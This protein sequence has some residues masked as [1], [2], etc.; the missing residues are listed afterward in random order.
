MRILNAIELKPRRTVRIALW[1][2]EEQ[3]LLGSKGYVTQ[4]FGSF[5]LSTAP[6]QMELPEFM[7]KAG[8]PLT[9]STDQ[10]HLRLFQ[11]GQEQAGFAVSTPRATLRW[12]PSLRNGWLR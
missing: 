9:L 6:D 3:G 12:I 8:G 1:S 10:N 5:P 2:G 7:R 4:H 11:F